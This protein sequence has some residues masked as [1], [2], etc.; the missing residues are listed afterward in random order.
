MIT[1][2]QV[3]D[4][5]GADDQIDL[6]RIDADATRSGNQR[7]EFIGDDRFDDSGQIRFAYSGSNT[8][9]YGS[10]DNDTSAEFSLRLNGRI[11]LASADFIA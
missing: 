5:E 8:I 6:S 2:F 9:V 10:T 11:D 4:G 1:D 3:N 7:F